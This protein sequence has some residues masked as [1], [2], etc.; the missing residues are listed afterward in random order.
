MVNQPQD[1][2][3]GT[4]DGDMPDDVRS[5]ILFNKDTNNLVWIMRVGKGQKITVPFRYSI[6]W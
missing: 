1:V 2:D 4:R 6:D 5:Q 3:V